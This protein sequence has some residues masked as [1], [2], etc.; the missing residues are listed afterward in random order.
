MAVGSVVADL[1]AEDAADPERR[2]EPG[3]FRS[4]GR[5]LRILMLL[6]ALVVL[7]GAIL[8]AAILV[9]GS[10]TDEPTGNGSAPIV[11]QDGAAGPEAP[12]PD[13]GDCAVDPGAVAVSTTTTSN[14]PDSHGTTIRGETTITNTGDVPVN[15][16]WRSSQ[17]T[18]H[19]NSGAELLDEGWYGGPF[20]LQ[21]GETRTELVGVRVFDSGERTWTLITDLAAFADSPACL[22]QVLQE[23][24][25]AYEQYAR[26]VE[27]PFPAGP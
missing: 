13:A 2:T 14:V 16:A 4:R 18:G 25:T 21:P 10:R 9:I 1:V 17:S 3:V 7:G 12:P 15:V 6:F 5:W 20:L 26:P 8:A 24:D 23:P 22:N 19:D 11:A 27:N